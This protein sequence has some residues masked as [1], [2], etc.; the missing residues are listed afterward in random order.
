MINTTDLLV[1][2]NRRAV[3]QNV[4]TII[5]KL[6]DCPVHAV[7]DEKSLLRDLGID[8]IAMAELL[9]ELEDQFNIDIA[10]HFWANASSVQQV[11]QLVQTLTSLDESDSVLPAICITHLLQSLN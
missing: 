5:A 7:T 10:E 4:R 2:Y 6:I 3:A 8:S 11:V 9:M 1:S